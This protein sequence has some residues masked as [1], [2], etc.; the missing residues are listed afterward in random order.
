MLLRGL[1]QMFGE[2]AAFEMAMKDPILMLYTTRSIQRSFS[3][4]T[5]L[6]TSDCR[7]KALE[8]ARKNPRC[9]TIAEYEYQRTKPSL[10]SMSTTATFIDA[11]RPLG[12]GGLA[13]AI[14]GGFVLLIVVLRP[15]LYGA[16]GG[17]SALSA[18]TGGL[19]QIPRPY[20][21]AQ[22]NGI[23]LASFVALI[24]IYQVLSAMA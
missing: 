15:I 3:Y 5:G 19:P 18:M 24:P 23:N 11:I 22:A 6:E 13:V 8:I 21:I 4:I 10:D 12:E 17:Q 9:L 20:E 16:G 1:V 2:D 7:G 14:F